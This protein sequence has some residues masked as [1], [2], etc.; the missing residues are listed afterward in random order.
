MAVS[1][2]K[3]KETYFDIRELFCETQTW[4]GGIL[5]GKPVKK[6]S[7]KRMTGFKFESENGE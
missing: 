3:C 6:L 7:H 1:S 4:P 5:E 2:V